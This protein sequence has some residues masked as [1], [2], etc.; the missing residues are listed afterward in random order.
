[1]RDSLTLCVVVFA[2]YAAAVLAV[3]TS[4]IILTAFPHPFTL[5]CCQFLCAT[6]ITQVG[7]Y[8]RQ[9]QK[10][11]NAHFAL[12]LRIAIA[13]TC[14]F[15]FT[16]LS[17]SLIR[18]NLA[19]TIKSAE[20]VSS[21]LLGYFLIGEVRSV[22]AYLALLPICIGVGMSCY[23]AGEMDL[24]GFLFAVFSNFCFSYRAVIGKH[25]HSV[26][27][28]DMDELVLFSNI[29]FVGLFI[30]FPLSTFL[31][32]SSIK[33]QSFADMDI[34]LLALLVVNGCAYTMYNTLSF[35]ALNRSSVFSHAVFNVIRRVV[36]I[37][38]S[39]AYFQITLELLNWFG[40]LIAIGGVG[41]FVAVTVLC[42]K[43][44]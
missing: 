14:G 3:I 9:P 21:V 34:K 10:I 8:I 7:N 29:S 15:V 19:E 41:C 42:T 31:E 43:S 1:M 39:V 2:W 26:T 25:L 11:P 4:K 30:T 18:V 17:F 40:V 38:F 32:S 23:G 24:G 20:P 13:Y 5:C 6:I 33:D 37:L 36:I 22:W 27:S 44:A 16:N 28:G 35:A 12:V